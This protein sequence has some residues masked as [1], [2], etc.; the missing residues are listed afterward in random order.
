MT[1]KDALEYYQADYHIQVHSQHYAHDDYYWARAEASAK[2]N[3]PGLDHEPEARVLEFGCGYGQN[4]AC[5]V[6]AWGYDISEVAR[7]ECQKHGVKVYQTIP[8]IPAEAFDIVLSRHCL[9]H[10]EEP[11]SNLCLLRAFLK[12]GGKLIL[13]LPKERHSFTSY[14]PDVNQHLY[15]WNFRTINNLLARADYQVELNKY[16]S[17]IG[18]C[19]LLPLRRVV[20]KEI[21]YRATLLAGRIFGVTELVI[22]ARRPTGQ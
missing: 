22:H 3:L 13:I 8:E 18:Y 16:Q 10:L 7:Q 12:P 9:E 14:Q 20:G 4:I 17:V 15:C 2:L 6:N 19:A 11:L 5:L 1:E 21:Y